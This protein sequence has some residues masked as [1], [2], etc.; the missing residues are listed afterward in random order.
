ML[1]SG[2]PRGAGGRASFSSTRAAQG[3]AACAW[4]DSRNGPGRGA[5]PPPLRIRQ[6]GRVETVPTP[7]PRGPGPR[8]DDLR[9]RSP[10][11]CPPDS[12]LLAPSA[13]ELR[14][15]DARTNGRADRWRAPGLAGGGQAAGA[16]AARP[17]NNAARQLGP[18]RAAGKGGADLDSEGT[19]RPAEAREGWKEDRQ[20]GG[21]APPARQSPYPGPRAGGPR[22][23]LAEGAP[24][25]PA[26][27]QRP[28][29][30]QDSCLR[31]RER[32]R[33]TNSASRIP[34]SRV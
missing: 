26:Q 7:G 12:R 8:P 23:A 28:V 11:L 9:A 19:R 21:A 20:G 18:V 17:V 14:S 24:Q 34:C 25:I 2:R 6:R 3:P 16:R 30:P 31:A 15:S 29:Q 27:P 13:P 4:E 32:P 10:A 1:R 33:L 5:R 22:R